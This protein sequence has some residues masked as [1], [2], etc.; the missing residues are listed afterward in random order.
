MIPPSPWMHRLHYP[1]ISKLFPKGIGLSLFPGAMINSSDKGNLREKG[2]FQLAHQGAVHQK[3]RQ[4][5]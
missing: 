3:P 4:W 2:S 5:A 1:W